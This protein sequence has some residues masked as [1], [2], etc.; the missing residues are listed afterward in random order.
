MTSIL[1]IFMFTEPQLSL[2]SDPVF[3]S[4]EKIGILTQQLFTASKTKS[5]VGRDSY[6]D[7]EVKREKSGAGSTSKQ[8]GV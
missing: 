3:F 8:S 6:R 5:G 1:L 2:T 7:K 4:P